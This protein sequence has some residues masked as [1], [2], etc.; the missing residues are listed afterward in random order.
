MHN[1]R[2]ISIYYVHIA[3]KTVTNQLCYKNQFFFSPVFIYLI[4]WMLAKKQYSAICKKRFHAKV[5]K[6]WKKAM[7]LKKKMRSKNFKRDFICS[8]VF[9]AEQ[10]RERERKKERGYIIP[11]YLNKFFYEPKIVCYRLTKSNG[12]AHC[13]HFHKHACLLNRHIES[14]GNILIQWNR[15]SILIYLNFISK[16][17][18]RMEWER[19]RCFDEAW[20]QFYS[21]G[22]KVAVV[23]IRVAMLRN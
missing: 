1:Q 5:H 12:C 8:H 20:G 15:S 9:R 10:T 7:N 14:F 23:D 11:F 3:V 19:F 18:Y 21:P 22:I 6:N 2:A 4:L 16:V 17:Q 13:I